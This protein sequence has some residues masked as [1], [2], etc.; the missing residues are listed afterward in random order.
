MSY[1]ERMLERFARER[2]RASRN[3]VFNLEEDTELTHFGQSL[4]NID[5]FDN[6]PLASD[7]DDSEENGKRKGQVD[8][9]TVA[10]QHFGGFD[11]DEPKDEV[12]LSYFFCLLQD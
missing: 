12:G 6:I 2:Q 9:R 8:A 10:Q 1:E 3:S 11:E 5:D 7:S 4:S